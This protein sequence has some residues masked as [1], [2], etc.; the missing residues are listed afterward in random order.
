MAFETVDYSDPRK[1]LEE[2]EEGPATDHA[3][4]ATAVG[5]LVAWLLEGGNLGLIGFRAYVVAHKLRPDLINGMSLDCIARKLGHGRS[6]AHK[7]SKDLTEVF[8]IRGIN[9]RSEA[10][11]QKYREA[12]AR[13]HATMPHAYQPAKIY[14]HTPPT[15]RTV[16]TK[17]GNQRACGGCAAGG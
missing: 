7:L 8:Q 12:W 11:R 16:R 2:S 1:L 17:Q 5:R 10:A 6:S 15:S 13:S 4:L 3:E 9:D 14:D